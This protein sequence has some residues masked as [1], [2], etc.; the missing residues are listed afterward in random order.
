MD[1]L[2]AAALVAA[3]LLALSA[4]AC[5]LAAGVQ[6]NVLLYL[7]LH[8]RLRQFKDKRRF[9]PVQTLADLD[10]LNEA[11]GRGEAPEQATRYE[12]PP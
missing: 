4:G 12:D 5:L 6:A 3:W 1:F 2:N 9:I 8:D 11:L 10:A 7:H